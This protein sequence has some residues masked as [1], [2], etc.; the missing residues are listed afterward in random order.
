MKEL[1]DPPLSSKMISIRKGLDRKISLNL[2]IKSLKKHPRT[3]MKLE[4]NKL[5]F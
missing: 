1:A 5:A 2:K 3:Y 4:I